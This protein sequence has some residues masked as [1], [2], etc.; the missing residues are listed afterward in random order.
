MAELDET[1]AYRLSEMAAITGVPQSTLTRWARLGLINAQKLG[2]NWRISGKWIQ[3]YL[4]H[5]AVSKEG[6]ETNDKDP[7][8]T[9]Q[10]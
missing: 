3:Y 2:R 1:R 9:G 4:D 10:D 8:Q 5:G 6:I 7:M